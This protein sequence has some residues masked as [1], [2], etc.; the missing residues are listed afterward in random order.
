MLREHD[1]D[2]G[3]DRPAPR[4]LRLAT[5]AALLALTAGVAALRGPAFGGEAAPAADPGAFPL[6]YVGRD[7][8]GLI[9]FRPAATFRRAGMAVYASR[10]E[11]LARM[12]LFQ[13]YAEIMGGREP[14]V[15]PDA[16][17]F[18]KL[19]AEDLELVTVGLAIGRR[20]HNA[21]R[22]GG[23]DLPELHSLEVSGTTIRTVRPFDWSK[24]LRQWGLEW[25]E[26]VAGGRTYGKISGPWARLLGRTPCVLVLDERTVV[27][28]E[29]DRASR[30]GPTS[31]EAGPGRR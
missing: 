28:D 9:A 1:S 11:H 31:G 17:G 12:L 4:R 14:E 15:D 2:R 25:T 6:P 26:A 8:C 10:L 18:L 21:A 20:P 19:R 22:D 29:E 13:G 3:F 24:C 7:K 30:A 27:F 23:P 16:P 5:A